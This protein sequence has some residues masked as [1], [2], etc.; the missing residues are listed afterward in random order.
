MKISTLFNV[1]LILFLLL[2]TFGVVAKRL[3]PIDILLVTAAFLA[4][5]STQWF[6][7]LSCGK[8]AHFFIRRNQNRAAEF[9]SRIG[10]AVS[11]PWDSHFFKG[12]NL[13][14]H[15]TPAM[16]CSNYLR[17]ALHNQGKFAE[18][19]VLDLEF[20]KTVESESGTAEGRG[21][22]KSKLAASV[23]KAGELVKAL[24]LANEAIEQF[25]MARLEERAAEVG[26]ERFM[27]ARGRAFAAEKA[28]AFFIRATILESILRYDAALIDRQKALHISEGVFGVDS[29]DSTPHITMLGKCYLKLNDFENAE[30]FLRR[31]LEIR[32]RLLPPGD[33]LVSSAQLALS[34]YFCE[35][36]DLEKADEMLAVAME[37][38]EKNYNHSPGPGIA[39]YYRSAAFLRQKQERTQEADLYFKN[40]RE[41]FLKYFPNDHPIFYELNTRMIQF[42]TDNGRKDETQE[43]AE[44][45]ARISE[46]I[47]QAQEKVK[48]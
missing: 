6:L 2:L 20:L 21:S 33:K 39:E 4:V 35:K 16:S 47:A 5:L 25:G 11:K 46:K 1:T 23:H 37:V 7:P 32:L 42:L 48:L 31:S 38:A 14:R 22:A 34:D 28:H 41:T 3:P 36:G 30:S 8:M 27:E 18:Q 9:V 13:P 19:Q 10:L 45:Q 40:A 43:I 12:S 15:M 44:N 17:L 29:K 24:E 26:N